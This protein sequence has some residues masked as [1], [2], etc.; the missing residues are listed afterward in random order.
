MTTS[1][2]SITVWFGE[3]LPGEWFTEPPTIT[4]DGDEILVVGTLPDG[5]DVRG[6]REDTRERR[7]QLAEEAQRA[8]GRTVS[9]GAR[10]AGGDGERLF[11]HLATP[12]MTRLRLPERQVLDT[13][14]AAG[15]ARS[16]SEALAWCVRLVGKHESSWLQDLRDALQH[17]E[18]ARTEGPVAL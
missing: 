1:A 8:F 17:V 5:T 18:R 6:F 16:R 13:L 10:A 7:M 12:V 14:I 3:H 15:V 4:T 2:D 9:W 11:T